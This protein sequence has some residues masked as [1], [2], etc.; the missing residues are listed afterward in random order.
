[1]STRD[2]NYIESERFITKAD[3]TNCLIT[4]DE[5]LARR[6]ATLDIGLGSCCF[7]QRVYL[8][9]PDLELARGDK[10]EQLVAVLF[11]TLPGGDVSV[12]NRAHEPD[13][14]GT[15]LE[16]AEGGDGS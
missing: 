13:V 10:V 6:L 5:Q 1:M 3:D 4:L 9:D 11:Q 12:D 8:V 15:E 14:L 2:D 16:N 7:R